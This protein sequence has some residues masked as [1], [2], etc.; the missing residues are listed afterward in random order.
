MMVFFR[1]TQAP[2]AGR[3]A[4]L[5]QEGKRSYF[6]RLGYCKDLIKV[7]S[8]EGESSSRLSLCVVVTYGNLCF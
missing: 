5:L 6:A 7:R 2:R 4:R 3:V 8:A 1:Q